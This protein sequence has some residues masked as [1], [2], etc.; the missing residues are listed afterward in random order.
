MAPRLLE[1]VL[2]TKGNCSLCLKAKRVLQETQRQQPFRLV[3]VDITS[4]EE[5]YERYKHDIPVVTLNGE[6]IFRHRVEP[7]RLTTILKERNKT[8]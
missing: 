8:T 3:E 5:W 7:K 4:N 6:E 2:Y 1:L